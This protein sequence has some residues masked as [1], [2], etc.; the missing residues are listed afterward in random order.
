MYWIGIG[1]AAI[2]CCSADPLVKSIICNACMTQ[3]A[4]S[5]LYRVRIQGNGSD[6]LVVV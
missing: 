6:G 4:L 2:A 3:A 1:N 5:Y